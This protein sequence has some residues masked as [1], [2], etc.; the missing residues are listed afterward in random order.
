MFPSADARGRVR[1]FGARAMR[2][3]QQPKYLNTSDGDLYHKRSQLFGID[4]ARGPAAKAG[5]AILVEGYTDVLALHQAGMRNAVGIMGT[6]F[7][8][9]QLAELQRVVTVLELCLDADDA[10]QAAMLKAAKLASGRGLELRVVPLPPGLD[11]ADLIAREGADALRERVAASEPFAVYHV[12]RILAQAD[13]G[14]AEGRDRAL[15]EIAPVLAAVPASVVRE[16]LLRRIAGRL[17]LSEAR[18]ATLLE[19]GGARAVSDA[20]NGSAGGPAPSPAPRPLDVDARAERSFL[21]LCV[22]LPRDGAAALAAIDPDLHLT[23]EPLRRAARHLEGRTDIPLTGL[24]PEDEQLAR[25]VAD[26]VQRAGRAPGVSPGQLEHARLQLELARL[27][28]Q[29]RRARAE[30]SGDVGALAREREAVRARIRQVV[31]RLEEVD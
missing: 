23:S 7:T 12:G 16:D 8:E 20:G 17:G 5:R 18:L 24:P 29:I 11:P 9:E 3:N 26:L 6:S 10:G 28:R 22:A 14:S 15:A 19:G 25:V 30:R 4:L 13:G 2:D 31:T 27:D 1:G 21:A